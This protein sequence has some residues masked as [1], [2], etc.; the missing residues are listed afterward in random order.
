MRQEKVKL[1]VPKLKSRGWPWAP[2]S[3]LVCVNLRS[4]SPAGTAGVPYA[5]GTDVRSFGELLSL[6]AI[7]SLCECFHMKI[8]QN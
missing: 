5:A 1:P 4:V 3:E 2:A 8:F 7:R 6:V